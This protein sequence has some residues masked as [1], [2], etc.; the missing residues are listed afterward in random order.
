MKT[1]VSK[2]LVLLAWI[3]F[4]IGVVISISVIRDLD[5]SV[6]KFR[7]S[8]FLASE[9]E[10]DQ[11]AARKKAVVSLVLFVASAFVF[12]SMGL[13]PFAANLLAYEIAYGRR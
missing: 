11:L 5:R 6:P 1:I 3:L 8:P 2:K 10:A 9:S 12:G 13:N 7:A 4:I